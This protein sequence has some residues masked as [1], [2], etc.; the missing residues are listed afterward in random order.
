M[1]KYVGVVEMGWKGTT[2]TVIFCA[3]ISIAFLHC[4]AD[5]ANT[6]LQSIFSSLWFFD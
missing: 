5:L 3:A 4:L 2:I 6:D 1:I